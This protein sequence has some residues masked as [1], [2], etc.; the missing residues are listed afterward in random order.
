MYTPQVG[1]LSA[2]RLTAADR[3]RVVDDLMR[4]RTVY[5]KLRMPK[6]MIESY[7]A[8]PHSPQRVRLRADDGLRVCGFQNADYAV[9]IRRQPGLCQLR[10]HCISGSRRR[11]PARLPGGIR[12]GAIFERSYR[13]GQRVNAVRDALVSREG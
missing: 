8:P 6:G 9:S 11:G 3:Q 12:V 5:S 2:E 1:E 4:L 7:V 13:I 10:L